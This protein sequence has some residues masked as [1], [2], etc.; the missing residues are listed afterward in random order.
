MITVHMGK[1]S[2]ILRKNEFLYVGIKMTSKYK[3]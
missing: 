1:K 3:F 2:E